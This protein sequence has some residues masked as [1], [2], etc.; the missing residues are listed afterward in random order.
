MRSPTLRS[1]AAFTVLELLVAIAIAAIVAGGGVLVWPRF[2]AALRLEV[3]LHQLAADLR[4]AQTLASA[5]AGR[6]RLV[7]ARG[8]TTYVRERADDAGTYRAD[9]TYR[10][11]PGITVADVNSGGD[12]IFSARGQAENGTVVLGDGRGVRRSL[13]INQ[14]GR[15]TVLPVAR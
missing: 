12:L 15:I 3:A 10:L 13:R 5:T 2:G 7:F 14:R 11:P 9:E 8:G 4:Q 6:V 1:H